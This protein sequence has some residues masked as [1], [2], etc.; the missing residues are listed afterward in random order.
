M[1]SWLDDH[2][3]EL[4]SNPNV[5]R[6]TSKQINYTSEFKKYLIRN[7]GLGI[8][9]IESFRRANFNISIFPKR[10]LK[11]TVDRL[12]K[13][14][15]KYGDIAFD[16]NRRGKGVRIA[17]TKKSIELSKTQLKA[18]IVHLESEVEFLKKLQALVIKQK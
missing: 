15:R 6:V 8:S 17:S 4:E 11:F 3:K 1:K 9:Y 12:L 16:S 13:I 14:H 7:H 5:L 2:R 10:Y 18:K